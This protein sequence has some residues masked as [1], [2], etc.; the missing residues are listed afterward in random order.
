VINAIDELRVKK[1]L[2][3]IGIHKKVLDLGCGDG[4][5]MKRIKAIG[6]NVEGVE[7]SNNAI[8]NARKNGFTVYDCSLNDDWSKN[9][10]KKYD[11]I[12]AGELIEHIFDTD[13]LLRNVRKVLKKGG[14]LI[15]TTPNIAALGR[16]LLLLLGKNPLV[17]TTTRNYDAGHIRYFTFGTLAKLLTENSFEVEDITSIHI[18]FSGNGKLYSTMLTKLFPKLGTT[19]VV[20]AKLK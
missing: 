15:I 16:R 6:N 8:K 11:V 2:N 12:F 3:L 18:N 13:K 14:Y 10:K 9:I 7:I 1:I 19:I 17:E 4:F 5:I 20:K